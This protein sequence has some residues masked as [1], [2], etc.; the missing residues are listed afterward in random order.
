MFFRGYLINGKFEF[1]FQPTGVTLSEKNFGEKN[2]VDTQ[3][4]CCKVLALLVQEFI[5][6]KSLS[7]PRTIVGIFV[8]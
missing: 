6:P 3:V 7:V 4:S 1:L 8:A 5:C 2:L